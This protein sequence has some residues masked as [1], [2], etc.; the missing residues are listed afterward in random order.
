MWNTVEILLIHYIKS[1][2]ILI[3]VAC[4]DIIYK[5]ANIC[6]LQQNTAMRPIQESYNGNEVSIITPA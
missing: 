1:F 6:C 4:N 2:Y 5:K 3:L